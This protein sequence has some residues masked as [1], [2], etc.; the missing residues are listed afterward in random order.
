MK[1]TDASLEVVDLP[2]GTWFAAYDMVLDSHNQP[3]AVLPVSDT[4]T[5]DFRNVNYRQKHVWRTTDGPGGP[6]K[7]T[8]HSAWVEPAGG[9][10]QFSANGSLIFDRADDAYFIYNKNNLGW[11]PWSSHDFGPY[12][13]RQDHMT[14]QGGDHLNIQQMTE[15]TVI[16][17][18]DR[19]DAPISTSGNKQVRIR[20]RNNSHSHDFVVAWT[21]NAD[22]A[23][24]LGKMQ[25]FTGATTTGDGATWKDYTFTITDAEWDGTLREL[26]ITPIAGA[27]A[28]AGDEVDIDYI[29][30]T[31]SAGTIAKQWEFNK[32]AEILTAQ[33]SPTDNWATWESGTL[34]LPGVSDTWVE[35]GFP[36]DKRRYAQGSGDSKVVSFGTTL[37]GGPLTESLNVHDFDLLGDTTLKFWNFDVDT[38]GWSAAKDV[39][40]FGYVSDSG[41]N[42]ITG[43][44]T[45]G[46]SQLKSADNLK[47]KLEAAA[48]TLHVRMKNGSTA[49][50]AAVCFT[51]DAAQTFTAGKCKTFAITANSGYTEYTV[52]MSTFAEWTSANTLRRLR[53][54][55]AD[56]ASTGT[57]HIGRVYIGT[58]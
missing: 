25:T 28:V 6:G 14:W 57:F 17:T 5:D 13:L 26:E 35:A 36:I 29:R 33:A 24:T 37:Q 58:S 21:T 41:A 45:G 1:V 46:D 2:Y 9:N 20:M 4:V 52:D 3:H 7:G 31:N 55:P 51:T 12:E 42:S 18:N 56:N 10:S 15:T 39:G 34:L 22:P 38:Q 50:Q 16:R 48:H 19:V 47:V 54:D 43:T 40:S 32:G 23:W 53:I 11:A 49:T 44:I 27:S 8:W 30:V